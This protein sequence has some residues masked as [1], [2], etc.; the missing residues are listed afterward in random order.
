MTR[1]ERIPSQRGGG[2]RQTGRSTP[3]DRWGFAP[4]FFKKKEWTDT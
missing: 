1:E 3:E 2:E 4:L